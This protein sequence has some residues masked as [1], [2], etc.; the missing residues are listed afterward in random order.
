MTEQRIGVASFLPQVFEDSLAGEQ[1][2]AE[3]LAEPNKDSSALDL[4][5]HGLS[6]IVVS[7]MAETGRRARDRK[8]VEGLDSSQGAFTV[9]ARIS[10][11]EIL[12]K[13]IQHGVYKHL[14]ELVTGAASAAGDERKIK[15]GFELGKRIV[16]QRAQEAA[17]EIGMSFIYPG[18]ELT[19]LD[20]EKGTTLFERVI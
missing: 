5:S 17:T 11:Y 12:Y 9:E 6:A 15:H 16:S 8:H 7:N 13:D 2:F 19:E 4:V 1:A 10:G 14:T 3:T 18:I 20:K